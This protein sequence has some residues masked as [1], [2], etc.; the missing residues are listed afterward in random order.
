VLV[1]PAGGTNRTTP[2]TLT[3]INDPGSRYYALPDPASGSI[4]NATLRTALTALDPV[5][6]RAATGVTGLPISA[7]QYNFTSPYPGGVFP[8]YRS[9]D[10]N[11]GF[12]EY[13]VN[14]QNNYT[15]SSGILKGFAVLA[16]VQTFFKDRAYYVTTPGQARYLYRQPPSTVF[17]LGL[18]YQRRLTAR[19][20]WSTQLHVRNLLN[21]YKVVVMPSA[22]NGTQFLAKL[23]RQ[24]RVWAWTNTISF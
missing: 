24:P 7:I 1:D 12:A 15:F 8:I 21:H 13:T 10:K 4:T 23:S 19:H 20:T 16:D 11:T 17:N 6:G 3:M 5:R 22:A 9:T 2:L 18:T 14:A